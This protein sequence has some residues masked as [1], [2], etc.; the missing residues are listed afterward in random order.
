MPGEFKVFSLVFIDLLENISFSH[1]NGRR[2]P[3]CHN[4]VQNLKNIDIES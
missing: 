3:F 4:I 1:R 2:I